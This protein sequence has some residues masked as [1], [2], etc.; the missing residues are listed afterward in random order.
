VLP[1]SF[2]K[3][4]LLPKLLENPRDGKIRITANH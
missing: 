4:I 1:F 2:L 3:K